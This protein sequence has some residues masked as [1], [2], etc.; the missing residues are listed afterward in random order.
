MPSPPFDI[1]ASLR[2]HGGALRQLALVLLHDAADA[3]DAVQEVWLGALQRPPA[4]GR[5]IGGWLATAMHNVARKL[6]RGDARRARRQAAVAREAISE[7]HAVSFAREDAAHRLI[8]AVATLESPYRETVWQRY[9]EGLAPRQIAAKSGAPI[10][11]VRSR[12]QRGLQRLRERLGDA[13]K[14]DWRGALTIAFGWHGSGTAATATVFAV[15]GAILMTTWKLVTGVVLAGALVWLAWSPGEIRPDTGAANDTDSPP[16][17]A[18]AHEGRGNPTSTRPD[19]IA[20]APAIANEPATPSTATPPT[21]IKVRVRDQAG[22]AVAGAT[23][24]FVRPGFAYANLAAEQADR[25]SRSTESFLRD[26]GNS[27]I[28]DSNGMTRVPVDAAQQVIVARKGDRYGTNWPRTDGDVQE[29]VVSRHHTLVVETADALGNPV[30]RVK[31]VAGPP[32]HPLTPWVLGTT[33]DVGRLTYVLKPPAKHDPPKLWLHAELVDGA[34]GRQAIDRHEPPAFVRLTV[35]ATGTV[36][37]TITNAGGGTPSADVLAALYAELTAAGESPGARRFERPDARGHALFENVPLDAK[38]Q[39][40]FPGM[41]LE[42][43]RFTG[44]TADEREVHVVATIASGHPFLAGR[45]VNPDDTPIASQ[46]VAVFCRSGTDML[47]SVGADTD[48]QG[49][50]IAYL[51]DHCLDE[52]DVVF[53]LGLGMTGAGYAREVQVPVAGVLRGR[54]DV[55][56]VEM[57]ND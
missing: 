18:A 13:G 51:S 45:L 40:R 49:R 32:Y 39:L 16:T 2:R 27:T 19:R 28:T 25:Y 55:G 42:P 10:A 56:K 14:A 3:E 17:I 38:L 35:P 11:T 15:Q 9:F 48:A 46:R 50:F 47:A 1:E 23:V 30:P 37:A 7:D 41:I 36:R 24:L 57:P 6:R 21:F 4:D 34:H 26:Y 33:D 31:V 12:L 8:T 29:I 54:I 53:T 43:Q 52:S 20:A 22:M 5:S 44:P